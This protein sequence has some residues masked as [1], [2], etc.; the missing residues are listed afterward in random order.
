MN[1]WFSI[2]YIY[3]HIWDVILPIDELIF[4]KMVKTTNQYHIDYNIH[5]VR[6]LHSESVAQRYSSDQIL[7]R[8]D[9]CCIHTPLEVSI[10]RV[11]QYTPAVHEFIVYAPAWFAL[12]CFVEFSMA[13]LNT[14]DSFLTTH[15]TGLSRV[16]WTR[17]TPARLISI[18]PLK[19]PPVRKTIFWNMWF[20][21]PRVQTNLMISSWIWRYLYWRVIT[22]IIPQ[23]QQLASHPSELWY[24]KGS[25]P[26]TH[27]NH[28]K[29]RSVVD[30]K[31]VDLVSYMCIPLAGFPPEIQRR[32]SPASALGLGRSCPANCRHFMWLAPSLSMAKS[33][34]SMRKFGKMSCEISIFGCLYPCFG[35]SQGTVAGNHIFDHHMWRF[36]LDV[37]VINP[38][39]VAV[40]PLGNLNWQGNSSLFVGNIGNFISEQIDSDFSAFD[41]NVWYH[42][43]L[44]WFVFFKSGL[45][46]VLT[47]SQLIAN[48]Q[49]LANAATQPWYHICWFWEL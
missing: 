13:H 15:A 48:P 25:T 41:G 18:L 17:P 5:H 30:Q 32:P 37:P 40:V 24:R 1:L 9:H 28:S 29:S 39:I 38:R 7:S 16:D 46:W 45:F 49:S 43:Y 19:S 6:N 27:L 36:P 33:M 22:G 21:E 11:C 20:W 14:G 26:I 47:Q 12:W 10:S 2:S 3:I 23:V 44:N 42:N 34:K 31:P 4:F 8:R 35:I